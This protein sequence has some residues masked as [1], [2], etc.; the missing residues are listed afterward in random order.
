MGKKNKLQDFEQEA[1]MRYKKKFAF[2]VFA[3]V[4]FL[5]G[6]APLKGQEW[7]PILETI[8]PL[9]SPSGYENLQLAKIKAYLPDRW[10]TDNLG[11]LVMASPNQPVEAIMAAAVD[12]IGYFVSGLTADGYLRLDRTQAVPYQLYDSFLMGHGVVVW[13]RKGLVTGVV[14]QPAVH[15]LSRERREK[16]E[17]GIS[18]D[19]IYVDIGARSEAEVRA[20]GVEILDAVT[21]ERALT[22]LNS[23]RV[24]G[25]CLSEKLFASLL[26]SLARSFKEPSFTREK[27]LALAWVAQSRVSARGGRGGQSLGFL[28]LQNRWQPKKVIIL[29]GRQAEE[30]ETKP[31]P[32]LEQLTIMLIAEE[33][34][35]G[36]AA[37]LLELASAN[38]IPLQVIAREDS[39]MLRPF[40]A[41][42][43]E[44]L[45]L[46]LPLRDAATP[47]ETVSLRDVDSL[48]RLLHLFV[49]SGRIE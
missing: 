45:I 35:T 25:H 18:L 46:G 4:W 42:K 1:G 13:T 14:C 37:T 11:S 19:D 44:A 32:R 27:G 33:K 10:K 38:N 9:G 2:L 36:L 49:E 34:T 23:K 8:Y 3:W 16:L 40:Q 39:P 41:E 24:S 30:D 31:G 28:S 22:Y 5:L 20:R 26:S 15:I 6:L 17:R 7:H 47:A 48:V 12:E 43:A 21:R 29:G